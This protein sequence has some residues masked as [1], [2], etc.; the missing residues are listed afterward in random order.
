MTE[1]D[2]FWKIY[3]LEVYAIPT[4]RPLIRINHADTVFRSEKE[5][6]KAVVEE[7][8]EVHETGR[9]ILIGT[10][11]VDKSIKLSE[12]LKRKGIKHEL[13]NALPEHAARESEIV[14][15]AGRIGALTIATNMAGRGTDIILGGNPEAMGWAVLKTKY[16]S[17]LDVPED[18]WKT[19]ITDIEAKEKTKEEGRK[20]KD[21]GGLH[22][23]G[24]ERHDSRRIDNQLRGRA[25]RQGDPGSSRFYLSL[26]DD[27]MRIFM[28][29]WVANVLTRLGMEE[30]QAIES[31]MVSRQIQKS[32]EKS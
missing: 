27:L 2:E 30:G 17:R 21:L 19:I 32:P 5:K 23:V 29:E 22:I 11:D 3:E 25:G 15:Q 18:E 20:V 13:L 26:Q 8:V 16:A 12:L 9:P 31:P 6:W 14:S 10:T 4:N 24:T 7:V 1:A 28:G